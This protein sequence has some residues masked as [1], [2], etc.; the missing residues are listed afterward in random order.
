[1]E[2]YVG[3]ICPY[4]KQEIK[5]GDIVKVCP[6]CGVPH[7]QKCWDENNGCSTINCPEQNSGEKNIN[8]QNNSD[9]NVNISETSNES[10]SPLSSVKVCPNCGT[11]ITGSQT[12][13]PNCGMSLD[14]KEEKKK[15][16]GK[17]GAELQEGQLYCPN[18][19]HKVGDDSK[20]NNKFNNKNKDK[21]NIIVFAIIASVFLIVLFSIIKTPRVKEI[22]L[23]EDSI[24][25]YEE[26]TTQISYEIMPERASGADVSWKSSND[27]VASVDSKGTISALSE[28]SC[29]ISAIAEDKSDVVNV[30]VYD[31][32][33]DLKMIYSFF[34]SST[35]AYVGK[36]G[37]Y[38]IIDTNPYDIYD[39]SSE[40]AC[41]EIVKVNI[42]LG[43]PAY[44][45]N[46]MS[47]TTAL[48]GRQT[49]TFTDIGISVSWS[50]HPQNG[51][52]VMY[53]VIE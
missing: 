1:M 18:C 33:I 8:I 53:K 29:V 6:A 15:V 45:I 30:K 38:L 40:T 37:S 2:N 47:E 48:M 9:E 26:E 39:Y 21:V 31:N 25:M 44:V 5:K 43:L 36:D 4:C 32:T 12:F 49:E 23:P 20:N 51:L 35:Y 7:H 24:E 41:E 50:Y 11:V 34:C 46:E 14:N 13:C 42:I 52:E 17:C 3:K 19:G 27:S 28:G 10:G 22:S 16:C